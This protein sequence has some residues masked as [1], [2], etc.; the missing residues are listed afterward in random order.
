MKIRN[1]FH[2]KQYP[3]KVFTQPSMTLPDE[4]MTMREILTRYSNGQPLG[5]AKVAIWDEEEIS[6]GI[7]PKKLDL[8]DW[9]NIR[10]NNNRAFQE[11][12]SAVKKA[13]KAKQ[14]AL[15]PEGQ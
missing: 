13:E 1:Q 9:D 12:E 15:V 8:T 3:G 7:N 11:Y 14:D 4:A 6:M 2:T 10:E 5:G